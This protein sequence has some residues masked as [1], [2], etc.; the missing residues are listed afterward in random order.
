MKIGI[1]KPSEDRVEP[2]GFYA[3]PA[4][5]LLYGELEKHKDYFVDI[6]KSLASLRQI[7]YQNEV[8]S[9]RKAIDVTGKTLEKI[10]KDINK[11]SV[12]SDIEKQ[13][14]IGF[15]KNG[16][17]KHGFDPI[18][19]S[20][21]N[22]ATIHYKENDGNLT[23]NSL[24]LLDVGAQVGDYSADV[25]R[26]YQ[27]GNASMRQKDILNA[28]IDVQ[29]QVISRIKPGETIKHLQE[30][31]DKELSKKYKK[32][33]IL[34]RTLPHGVSHHLGLDIHDFADYQTPLQENMI[35]TVEPG[36]YLPNENIGVRIE[37]DILV[38]KNGFE[39]L[40]GNITY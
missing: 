37:D 33:N 31:A 39:N 7:K 38:T 11:Y 4:K 36:I 35:I 12:E 5:K 26:T 22:A 17:D 23:R 15:L 14:T 18:V 30:F 29:R 27:V 13:L 19:A 40:S 2:Y 34:H 3:N 10:R 1:L 21:E 9:I 20:G 28:V 25:S 24:V 6:R 16:G 8:T 32:L